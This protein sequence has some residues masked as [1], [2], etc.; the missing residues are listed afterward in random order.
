MGASAAADTACNECFLGFVRSLVELIDLLLAMRRIAAEPFNLAA[1]LSSAAEL[2]A[3]I[4]ELIES[5]YQRVARDL[6][7]TN[8]G[9]VERFDR[10]D[11]F[12]RE[13]TLAYFAVRRCLEHH[14]GVPTSEL[15]ITY[16]RP[17]LVAGTSE[18]T[19]LGEP[20]PENTG[21]SLT[22]EVPKRQLA[23]GK[24]ISISEAEIE[25]IAFTLQHV[26]GPGFVNATAVES[27]QL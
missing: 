14:G 21:V 6:S 19:R 10:L 15:S 1:G 23:V 26:V 25:F 20:L 3:H 17:Y 7:L 18:I 16:Y 8:P 27:G 13:A 12:E 2:D 24:P 11:T 5:A 22:A 4:G 9:K